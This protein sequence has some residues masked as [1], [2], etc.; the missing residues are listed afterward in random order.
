MGL[1]EL[2]GGLG[3]SPKIIAAA[4]GVIV[5]VVAANYIV[6]MS[7]HREAA[8]V[9]LVQKAAAFTAVAD[10]AMAHAS[11]MS[12]N[13]M[14]D[15]KGL[16]A[17]AL[18]HIEK[19]GH[20]S[21]TNFFNAIPVIVGWKSAAAAASSE[22]I[23]F[24]IT[25]YQAR[26]KDNEPDPNSFQGKMLTDLGRQFDSGGELTISRIDEE[27]NTLHYMRAIRLNESCMSCHG[28]PAKYDMRDEAGAFD[29]K[30]PLGFAMEGWKPGDMHGAYEVALPLGPLDQQIAGFFGRGMAFTVPL[31]VIAGLGFTFLL[32]SLLG[33]PLNNLI[34]MIKDVATGDGDL[35][36]RLDLQRGDEIGKLGHWFDTF[37]GNLHGIIKQVSEATHSVAG[38]STQIA[39][40]A[41]QLTQGMTRQEEQT[42][43][44]AAAV[45]EMSHSVAEVAHKSADA[46][47]AA[48][49]AQ[50]QANDGGGVV[51]STIDEMQAISSEVG[52]SAKSVS[53]LGR[54]SEQIG[55]I[56]G[57]INDIAD[58]T[59]LLALNAA[60]EAARAGEH[61][62]GFAVVA[63]EVRKLAERTTQATDEVASSIREIQE[64][65]KRAV[66][67]IESGSGRVTKGVELA[68]SAGS[69]LRSIV[70]GSRELQSMV[71]GIAAASEQQ[72]SASE[73]IAQS[74]EAI[75]S[76]TRESV[77]GARQSAEAAANLSQ[78]AERLQELV[79]RF[80][81]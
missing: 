24:K 1:K 6:F 12:E 16:L 10:E 37:L 34:E 47:N 7:G 55:E 23:D 39:A 75:N 81:L 45:E 4:F 77:E 57:V 36:K 52:A 67:Q 38:A 26:N 44:V 19:G 2:K 49:G 56:I 63:D 41:E 35:T 9:A 51:R 78:Q 69:A 22:Q 73:A 58:Q 5:V 18:T 32:R 60:I 74:V 62:R 71:G 3:L 59:N 40:S 28:D 21:E 8:E 20:Y 27:T 13:N 14:I 72:S 30:D 68:E 50:E 17:E 31:V 33:K 61:G 53:E 25:S 64:Q 79:G 11:Y 42:T 80:K 76:V 70:E 29:G 15:K 48:T 54:K 66:E 43:Q 65:T 46:A